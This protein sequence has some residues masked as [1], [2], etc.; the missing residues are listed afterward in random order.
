MELSHILDSN[1]SREELD[2]ILS[3]TAEIKASHQK[4][5]WGKRYLRQVLEHKDIILYFNQPSTRTRLKFERAAKQLGADVEVITEIAYT[6]VVKG[7]DWQDTIKTCAEGGA[8]LIV[9]R[10]P[11]N[12][13]PKSAAAACQRYGFKTKIINAGDGNNHHPTQA[14]G[15]LFTLKEHFGERF[16]KETL[17]IAIGADLKNSRVVHSLVAALS[18]YPVKLTLVSW[19]DFRLPRK[20]LRPLIENKREFKEIGKLVE[21]E[22]FDMIYWVRLQIEHLI[23]DFR[24]FHQRAYNQS[25]RIDKR[26][27]NTFLKD[28]GILMYPGPRAGE[29]DKRIDSDPRVKGDQ[30]VENGTFTSMALFKMMLNPQFYI[31]GLSEI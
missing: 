1:H 4:N 17:N 7:E 24:E 20:Y 16:G 10:H 19:L 18:Q 11:Q 3:E 8:D 26:F 14:F 31:P 22:K 15:D 28:D 21:G 13:A 6:S 29:L 23:E 30:Q 9:I 12:F 27:L 25:F 5:D 2:E